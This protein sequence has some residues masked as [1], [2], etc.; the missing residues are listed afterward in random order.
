[1]KILDGRES[2]YQWDVNQ[3]LTSAKLAEGD[4]VHFY[5]VTLARALVVKAYKLDGVIVADVPNILLQR[6]HE[7]VGYQYI[8]DGDCRRTCESFSFAVTPRPMPEDY[9][10]TETEILNYKFLEER[11]QQLE[12]YGVSDAKLDKAVDKY[13]IEHPVVMEESDPTVP[14]WAKQEK[15]PEYTA[16]EV[17]AI[18]K[19]TPIPPITYVESLDFT[20][21]ETLK[22]IRALESGTYILYGRFTPFEGSDEVLAFS[23]GMLASVIKR[24][25]VTYMQIF[26]PES[27]TVQ[28]LE[29]TDN[30]CSRTNSALLNM[31][32]TENKV[33]EMDKNSTNEQYPTAKAVHVALTKKED[34]ENKTAEITEQS[35][36]KQYPSAK[37]VYTK[38]T[39]KEKTANKVQEISEFSTADQYPSAKAV[40]DWSKKHETVDH[41]V[42]RIDEKSTHEQYPTAKAVFEANKGSYVPQMSVMDE[43][44]FEKF[45][46]GEKDYFFSQA[47]WDDLQRYNRAY[48]QCYDEDDDLRLGD[49]GKGMY[50]LKAICR[51]GAGTVPRYPW[52]KKSDWVTKYRE[53]NPQTSLTD[54][55]II[56]NHPPKDADFEYMATLI[57]RQP[58]GFIKVPTGFP[59][60]KTEAQMEGYTVPKK[61]ADSIKDIALGAVQKIDCPD[62]NR[63]AY[64]VSMNNKGESIISL[65]K[66]GANP[67]PDVNQP[68]IRRR[69]NGAVGTLKIP[70]ADDDAASKYY[71]DTLNNGANKA[72]S[73]GNYSTMITALN[74]LPKDAYK[75]G[76]NI[77]IVTLNV[78]DLWVSEVATSTVG[79][80][81]SN[82]AAFINS[83]KTDGYVQVGYYKLSMLETQKVDLTAYPTTAQLTSGA[84]VPKDATNATRATYAGTDTSK[85]TIEARLAD[86]EGHSATTPAPTLNSDKKLSDGN[87]YY[88]I[89]LWMGLSTRLGQGI[90]HHNGSTGTGTKL[91]IKSPIEKFEGFI[92]VSPNG[93]MDLYT[94]AADGSYSKETSAVYKIETAK[95]F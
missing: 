93:Q 36:D 35:T 19:D 80:S 6:P 15:K 3:R 68:L 63:Y 95:I 31:E 25:V 76:Q 73:Y 49:D 86:L 65:I 18:P 83:L 10:Y 33:P 8:T 77:M 72:V 22:T 26:Y 90:V 50:A 46:T 13:F 88:Y 9:I 61:Y 74:N 43:M 56:K 64:T 2:F 82:D 81:C 38:L 32:S 87:G 70:Q 91:Y 20:S 30:A 5:N 40:F 11:L 67:T 69:T 44:M 12:E 48:V 7:I 94:I 34:A 29:I 1:M 54:A 28:Y 66:M 60:D 62:K 51:F 57:E 92:Q 41:K 14:E 45:G 85:G 84:V 16:E 24:N 58:N 71:V 79:Y 4:E 23:S 52:M 47:N 27:N 75:V 21:L 59:T 37:A 55:A 39:K 42:T 89:E 17:G 53:N 78:P